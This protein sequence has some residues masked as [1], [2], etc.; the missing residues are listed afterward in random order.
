MGGES[1]DSDEFDLLFELVLAVMFMCIGIVGIVTMTRQFT[2]Q[3]E[4]TSRVD[5]VS[6]GTIDQEEIYPFDFTG[7]QA[8]MFAWMMDGHDDTAILWSNCASDANLPEDEDALTYDDNFILLDP[9]KDAAGFIVKRNRAIVG[10]DEYAAGSVKGVLANS[11]TNEH[12]WKIYKGLPLSADSSPV[13]WYLDYTLIHS[14]KLTQEYDNGDPL[15]GNKLD[16]WTD[17]I[18]TIHPRL[19]GEV[20]P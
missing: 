2:R 19:N 6:V 9:K 18:W 13:L 16:E 10:S 17:Y 15:T 8:Y 7:Y 20:S 12:L 1:I 11:T 3:T 14:K 5:K 4:V